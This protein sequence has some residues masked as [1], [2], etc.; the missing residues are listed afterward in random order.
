MTSRMTMASLLEALLGK[1]VCLSGDLEVGVDQQQYNVDNLIKKQEAEAIL[2]KHGFSGTGKEAYICGKT[3]K[4]LEATIL[5]GI[6]SYARLFHLAARKRHAR[7]IGPIDALTRQ[8]NCGKSN[9]GGLRTGEMECSALAAFGASNTL[10][11]RTRENS[12]GYTVYICSKCS[13]ITNSCETIEY[14]WCNTC[15]DDQ[16]ILKCKL[17]FALLVMSFELQAAGISLKLDVAEDTENTLFG[18]VTSSSAIFV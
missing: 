16:H 18:D 3:G 17:P 12:D 8:P 14:F 7:S 13:N 10:Q 5:T 11:N 2:R 6:V 9:G 15:D 1:A 4:M